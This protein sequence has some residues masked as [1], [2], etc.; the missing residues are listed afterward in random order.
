MSE[1]ARKPPIRKN[2]PTMGRH[3]ALA[4]FLASRSKR[5]PGGVGSDHGWG[6]RG[7]CVG[8]HPPGGYCG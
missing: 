5:R 1:L 7:C 8:N 6:W 3:Q 2:V 4:S